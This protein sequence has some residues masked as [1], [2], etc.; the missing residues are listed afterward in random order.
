MLLACFVIIKI[1]ILFVHLLGLLIRGFERP[2]RLSLLLLCGKAMKRPEN[3]FNELTLA[4]S[5]KILKML[6]DF[7]DFCSNAN[8]Q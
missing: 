8:G 7:F 1:S 4:V 6:F 3:I 2:L 5:V